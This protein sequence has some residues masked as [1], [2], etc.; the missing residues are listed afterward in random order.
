MCYLLAKQNPDIKID[1]Y[2]FGGMHIKHTRKHYDDY[3]L[4]AMITKIWKDPPDFFIADSHSSHDKSIHNYL[5]RAIKVCNGIFLISPN[6]NGN[7][8]QTTILTNSSI[9]LKI[10]EVIQDTG[11]I[12][13]TTYKH[14]HFVPNSN[15]YNL[16]L[17]LDRQSDC[18]YNFDYINMTDNIK[19][20]INS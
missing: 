12:K 2:G 14:I 5:I 15:E 10:D 6:R 11:E 16:D 9:V 4:E 18:V 1:V 8:T 17:Y 7:L 13:F 19:E 3:S 20:L